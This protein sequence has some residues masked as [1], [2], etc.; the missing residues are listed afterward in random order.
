MILKDKKRVKLLDYNRECDCQKD[1]KEEKKSEKIK[2][3]TR[4]IVLNH[5]PSGELEREIQTSETWIQG[6]YHD[7]N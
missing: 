5:S 1:R 7:Q 3:R 6:R 4:R 2:V